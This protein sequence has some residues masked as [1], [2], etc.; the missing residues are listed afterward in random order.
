MDTFSKL[1]IQRNNCELILAGAACAPYIPRLNQ[2]GVPVGSEGHLTS[3]VPK[4]IVY[5]KIKL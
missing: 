5:Q 1:W 2:P 4:R 3:G